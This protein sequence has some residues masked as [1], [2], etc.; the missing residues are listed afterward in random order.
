[1]VNHGKY[2]H[3]VVLTRQCCRHVFQNFVQHSTVVLP[4]HLLF[5]R[6]ATMLFVGL[7]RNGSL[8]GAM[9]RFAMHFAFGIGAHLND[10]ATLP[11]SFDDDCPRAVVAFRL[12][13]LSGLAALINRLDDRVFVSVQHLL[14]SFVVAVVGAGDLNQAI[15]APFLA[16]D[17]GVH[18]RPGTFAVKASLVLLEIIEQGSICTRTLRTGNVGSG[19][20]RAIKTARPAVI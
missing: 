9:S 16:L 8:L 11:W 1:V 14:A 5:Q 7:L 2:K 10:F 4:V 13:A 6:A 18:F 15:R 20:K 19:G 3:F 12:L 17:V